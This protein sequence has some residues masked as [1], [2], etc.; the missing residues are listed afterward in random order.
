MKSIIRTLAF[1]FLVCIG[2]F[3]CVQMAIAQ[4]MNSAD[5][6]GSVTDST[7]ALVPG[8]QV[9]VLNVDTG[10]EK[11]VVTNA[12]GL[13][14]TSSIVD[15]HYKLTFTKEGFETMVRGPI[16]L[17]T[18]Y[19]TVNT[20]LKVGA[21]STSIT[22][23]TDVPLLQQDSGEH[24][25]TWNSNTLDMLPQVAAVGSQGQDWENQIAFL[26]GM[27]GSASTSY[28]VTGL[29]Q[30][31]S[32]NGSLPYNN[33]L[34]DG[35]SASLGGST[36]GAPTTQEVVGELQIS[37]S[38]FSAQY[39]QGGVIINQITKGGTSEFHGSAYDYIQNDAFDAASYAFPGQSVSVTF[40][41]Y[42]NFGGMING[43][44]LKKK[45]FFNFSYDQVLDHTAASTY[46]LTVPTPDIQG[47]NFATITNP[48]YDPTTQFI[49]LDSNNNPYPVRQSFATEYGNGNA[50]PG[51][52][53]DK[54]ANAVQQYYP[55]ETNH[56]SGGK[57]IPPTLGQYGVQTANFQS[58]LPTSTPYVKYFGR[59]DYD[60]TSK[61]RLTLSDTQ[62]DT[63]VIYP[64]SLTACPLGCEGGDV[65]NNVAQITDVWNISPTLINEARMGFTFQGNW[66]NDFSLNK[67]YAAK[68][69]WQFA[70][71]DDFP[72][73]W[74][75]NYSGLGAATNATGFENVFDPSD[76][77][78][79]IKG[80]HILH[81]GGEFLAYRINYTAWGNA[82]PG[83][84]YF[85]GQYTQQWTLDGGG[86]AT[87]NGNTGL[88]YADYLLGLPEYWAA[89][90]SPE[91]GGRLKSA[92]VF[93]QDD[94]KIRPNLTIN[95]GLRYQT[96]HG[97]NE[98]HGNMSSFDPT[99]TNP[100]DGTKGAMWFAS[101]HANG[102]TSMEKSVYTTILPRVGFS[103]SP[104]KDTTLRGGF[105]LYS[106]NW[107][108]DAYS[109]LTADGMGGAFN[110]SGNVS[111]VT[112]GIVPVT[113]M[114][115]SGNMYA[116]PVNNQSGLVMS[117][118]PLPYVAALTTPDAYNGQSVGYYQYAVP[119]PRVMQW[120]LSLQRMVSQ[121]TVLE[122]AYVASHGYNLSFLGDLNQIPQSLLSS[123]DA[124]FRAYPNF[125]SV[126]GSS[127]NGISNYNSLQAQYT[128]R[129]SNGLSMS[130]SYVWS[131]FL[132]DQ[133][134]G[135]SGRS[136]GARTYQ[137]GLNPSAE[138]G[139]SNFDT[140]N[141]FKA[142]GEYELPF[143]KGQHF[144]NHNAILD[145]VVGGWQFSA[146]ELLLSGT[147]FTVYIDAS[148]NVSYSLFSSSYPN[149]NPGVSP[150]PLHRSTE[151]WFNPAAFTQPAPGTFG[152][153]KRNSLYGPGINQTNLST[154]KTFNLPWE[155]IKLQL[156]MDATNAFNHPSFGTPNN[157]LA[158]SS[159]TGTPF[160]SYTRIRSLQ[161]GGRL[162]QFAAHLTF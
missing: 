140:R 131:H 108:L 118:T 19:T 148:D 57:F 1:N 45:M 16:T 132:D 11:I 4:S 32:A 137:N 6:R 3:C 72:T 129:M 162:V 75:N 65:D 117:T 134:S 126:S 67:G 143:G 101:T 33:V 25:V 42:H 122:L 94:W 83:T 44:I 136:A 52:M 24:T 27:S 111:D 70:K 102:R 79:L 63:P 37:L 119:V 142:Y 43:P 93:F 89:G 26:P 85:S 87:P 55:T 58:V 116:A 7:G 106:Y 107:T 144:L 104:N 59:L 149:W 133:D 152:N 151:N 112:N 139:A 9:S 90:V 13:Y 95:L 28:G 97:Y 62:N 76:V 12:S 114:D 153:V 18:G 78:T 98:P 54:V 147:P 5:L 40:L 17:Q 31:G 8:V 161:V 30:S 113:K 68:L 123:N 41:R 110:T 154:A 48:I 66:F 138:Y 128:K 88:D 71:V 29:G 92:Q 21:T 121:N 77:M 86:V 22:V 100:V 47:G 61:N 157:V 34:Q 20:Q 35:A 127:N 2:L 53:I 109:G 159:G 103:W 80:K 84:L 120:N 96:N 46:T 38:N 74:L 158:G 91:Y 49:Q 69:G 64:S 156:R 105:G 81:F 50:I 73:I 124:Q 36:Y 155:N 51:I 150:K 125:Q 82:N 146:S 135:G 15:G 60:I 56:L 99:V 130:A 23:T 141:A 39:G 10:V 115:S 160:T 145:S 14:D